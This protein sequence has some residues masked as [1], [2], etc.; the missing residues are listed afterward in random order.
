[1]HLHLHAGREVEH[2]SRRSRALDRQ[3]DQECQAGRK[4]R[5]SAW[6]R[7]HGHANVVAV[8]TADREDEGL[9]VPESDVATQR[10]EEEEGA[11]PTQLGNGRILVSASILSSLKL[12]CSICK[13]IIHG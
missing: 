6:T 8:S 7:R 11:R 4:D 9:V 1:M 12:F 13:E 3:P 10:R 2:E 5:F